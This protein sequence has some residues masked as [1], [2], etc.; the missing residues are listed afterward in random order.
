MTD[1]TSQNISLNDIGARYMSAL[2]HLSDLMVLTW[3]GARAVNEQGYE[4]TFR[5]VA[6]LP[7]TQFRFPLETAKAEAARW[8]FKNS[9]GE[10]LGLSL[11]FLE[12]IRKICGLVRFNA[13]KATAA[14]D[15]AALAAEINADNGPLDIPTRFKHLKSHYGLALPLEAELLSLVALHRCFLQTAGTVPKGAV[16]NVQ[17]KAIQPPAEG[18]K[19]PRL[20]DYTRTWKEGE[21]ISVSREEHAAVFTTISVFVSSMLTAVQDFSKAAGISEVRSPR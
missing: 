13:A 4:E 12:D 2:Q 8:W 14:G 20:A 1:P 15:L 11:V 5:S 16:L 18:E 7:S 17:L 19:E 10:V 9:L 21:R 3:A 6:G